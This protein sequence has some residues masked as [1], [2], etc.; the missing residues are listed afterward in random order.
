MKPIIG[1]AC[2][3]N[4]QTIGNKNGELIY[5]MNYD[6]K[7][8]QKTTITTKDKNKKNAVLMGNSTYKSMGKP[9]KNR[10]NYVITNNCVLKSDTEDLYYYNNVLTCLMEIQSNETIETIYIIGGATIYQFCLEHHL[11]DELI[12][13]YVHSPVN[14]TGDVYF[15]NIDF[16]KY[17]IDK[18]SNFINV[19]D[20]KS[21]KNQI[22][23][24]YYLKKYDHVC[25]DF[26]KTMTY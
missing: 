25:Q 9:L 6:M 2:I 12:L 3:S 22:Y 26:I 11:Y 15:P 5:Q 20:K 8:F 1:I 24:I 14:S 16:Y 18:K 19:F 23:T 7:H 21:E 10:I 4:N 13:S 17:Y